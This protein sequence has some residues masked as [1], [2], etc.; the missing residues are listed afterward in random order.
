MRV[1]TVGFIISIILISLQFSSEN[2]SPQQPPAFELIQTGKGIKFY[3]NSQGDY[4]QMIDLSQ[5]AQVLFLQGE[6]VGDGV[7]PA[8]NGINPQ[9]GGR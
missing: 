2:L 5:N 3:S 4:I 7:P 6:Q 1:K 9:F 8:Y